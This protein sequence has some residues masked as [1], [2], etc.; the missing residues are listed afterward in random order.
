MTTNPLITSDNLIRATGPFAILAGLI[1]AGIQ[2]IHPL[3]SSPPSPPARGRS[4][5]P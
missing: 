1:F 4:S 2:P 5:S 3:T